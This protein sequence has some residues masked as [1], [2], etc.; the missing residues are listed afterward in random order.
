MCSKAGV[1]LVYLPLYSPDLNPIKEFFTKLKAF[2]WRYWQSYKD[3]PGQGFDT[4]S[5]VLTLSVQ[6]NKVRKGSFGMQA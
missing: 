3:N 2:I 1:K 5:G 6:G 4:L